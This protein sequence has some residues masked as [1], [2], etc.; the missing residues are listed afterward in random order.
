M[1]VDSVK[2]GPAAF[3]K[4]TDGK[5]TIRGVVHSIRDIPTKKGTKKILVKVGDV[6]CKIFG[7]TAEEFIEKQSNYEGKEAEF[8]GRWDTSRPGRKEF[9]ID[10]PQRKPE[11]VTS[12]PATSSSLIDSIQQ[13]MHEAVTLTE[14]ERKQIAE[15][16]SSISADAAAESYPQ[17]GSGSH[18]S[19]QESQPVEQAEVGKDPEDGSDVLQGIMRDM[20]NIPTRSGLKMVTFRIGQYT[21]KMFG[22]IAESAHSKL[23]QQEGKAI[24][25]YGRWEINRRGIKEFIPAGDYKTLP[26]ENKSSTQLAS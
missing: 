11:P 18:A 6:V 10:G 25:V 9:V 20:K 8:Y 16:T 23:S 19:P 5:D 14:S 3:G 1:Q 2:I 24:A 7:Q 15:A 12:G 17:L 26:F 21:C 13:Q 22:K 4:T